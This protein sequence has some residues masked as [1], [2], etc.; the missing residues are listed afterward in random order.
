[1]DKNAFFATILKY[2][3]TYTACYPE[4]TNDLTLEGKMA[5][6]LSW[7]LTYNYSQS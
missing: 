1:M 4:G 3:V 7:P 6:L 5:R 2:N